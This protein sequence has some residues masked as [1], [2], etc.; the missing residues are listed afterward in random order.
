[1]SAI[2]LDVMLKFAKR[3]GFGLAGGA[4]QMQLQTIMP[5]ARRKAAQL[6]TAKLQQLRSAN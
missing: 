1:M 3:G 2:L 4:S 6:V 5:A